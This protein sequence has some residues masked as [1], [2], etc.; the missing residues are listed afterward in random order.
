MWDRE[1][2]DLLRSRLSGLPADTALD[3]DA[4][5]SAFGLDSMATFALI[6]ALEGAYSLNFRDAVLLP[7][8]F[9]TPRAIWSTLSAERAIVVRTVGS[10]E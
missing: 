7:L 3:A 8:N 1:F 4:P 2:E 5:L 6:A 10:S 9:R